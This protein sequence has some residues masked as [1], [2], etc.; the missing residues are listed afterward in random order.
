TA[1]W[2]QT[3][4]STQFRIGKQPVVVAGTPNLGDG[5]DVTLAGMPAIREFRA[6]AVRNDTTGIEYEAP[7]GSCGGTSALFF[8][9]VSSAIGYWLVQRPEASAMPSTA[10]APIASAFPL[11]SLLGVPLLMFGVMGL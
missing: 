5:D 3:V 9:V 6:Y 11:S 4:H 2:V 7:V 8:G 10:G 1:D